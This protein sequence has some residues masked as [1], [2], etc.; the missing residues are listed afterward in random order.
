MQVFG[1]LDQLEMDDAAPFA[2]PL[3][4]DEH[5]RILRFRLQPGQFIK[6]HHSRN[7]PFFGVVLKGRGV[8]TGDDGAK[9]EVGPHSV[10]RFDVGE[11][12]S[13]KALDEELVFVGFQVGVA[14]MSPVGKGGMLGRGE[15][16]KE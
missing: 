9:H 8:F 7:S 10:V 11:D 13:V 4:A 2:Q 1:L 5:S 6:E 3:W 12:H 16:V 15:G 14:E